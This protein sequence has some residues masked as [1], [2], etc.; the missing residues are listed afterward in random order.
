MKKVDLAIIE[1]SKLLGKGKELIESG[2][3]DIQDV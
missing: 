3:Y 1:S 2:K